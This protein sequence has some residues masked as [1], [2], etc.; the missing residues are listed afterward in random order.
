MPRKITDDEANNLNPTPMGKKHPIRAALETLR[1]KEILHISRDEFR[2]KKRTPLVFC[3][4]ISR[5]T[6]KKFEMK[7]AQNKK[8]WIVYRLE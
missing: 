1:E 7:N 3:N 4:Q 2:W 6:G 5:A 8:S